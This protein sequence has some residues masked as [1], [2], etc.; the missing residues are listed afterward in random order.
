V[1]PKLFERILDQTTKGPGTADPT[2][3]HVGG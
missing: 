1:E 2:M 3:R